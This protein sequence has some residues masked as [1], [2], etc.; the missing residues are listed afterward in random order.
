MEGWAC[1]SVVFVCLLT[2]TVC[3]L[4]EP[5]SL[6]N[7]TRVFPAR[8]PLI[9]AGAVCELSV[10]QPSC[11][12]VLKEMNHRMNGIRVKFRNHLVQTRSHSV[13]KGQFC[14]RFFNTQV[15]LFSHTVLMFARCPRIQFCNVLSA[16]LCFALC[17]LVIACLMAI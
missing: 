7:P 4:L 5:K 2:R 9:L 11:P 8:P 13:S 12:T 14:Q 6:T 10:C 1:Y 3:C 15:P 16:A 17:S